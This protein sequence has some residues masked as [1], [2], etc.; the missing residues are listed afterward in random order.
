[1]SPPLLTL[2]KKRA[3]KRTHLDQ[4]RPL[5]ESSRNLRRDFK[6]SFLSSNGIPAAR[7][8]NHSPQGRT[9]NGP[10]AR[11]ADVP[12]FKD[13]TSEEKVN[14]DSFPPNSHKQQRNRNILV[15]S[16]EMTENLK[17]ASIFSRKKS[18][19]L[20][21]QINHRHRSA[22]SNRLRRIGR[23]KRPNRQKPTTS[24]SRLTI[25]MILLNWFRQKPKLL[26]DPLQKHRQVM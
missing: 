11:S 12:L 22:S 21:Y 8:I 25:P 9:G 23:Q 1:M 13:T 24:L 18:Y 15:I 14:S 20:S 16:A 26:L 3:K 10:S 5:I 4:R 7:S 19:P 6:N 2:P 17:R